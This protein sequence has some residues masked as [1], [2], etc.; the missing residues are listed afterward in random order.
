MNLMVK[1]EPEEAKNS[2]RL[3]CPCMGTYD[4]HAYSRELCMD[5]CT[6]LQ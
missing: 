5:S 1:Q 2:A 6:S 4:D 3:Q